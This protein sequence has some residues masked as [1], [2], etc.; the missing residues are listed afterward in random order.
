MTRSYKP[1]AA[2]LALLVGALLAVA[3]LG[4]ASGAGGTHVNRQTWSQ[5]LG[6]G[7]VGVTTDANNGRG[8]TVTL[9]DYDLAAT[10]VNTKTL[11]APNGYPCGNASMSYDDLG[12]G[13][14]YKVT[15]HTSWVRNAPGGERCSYL[16]VADVPIASMWGPNG[17][18][19]NFP[20]GIDPGETITD[21][22]DYSGTATT[23]TQWTQMVD[24][25]ENTR[26]ACAYLSP[27]SAGYW[28][29]S[30]CSV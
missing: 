25:N 23:K 2:L 24:F 6:N 30:I 11:V 28:A 13:A 3:T 10:G 4:G 1:A 19:K 20:S 29:M 15:N 5:D 27:G 8:A 18:Y 26:Y 7:V 17:G 22:T 12:S 21:A 14:S 16:G 9:G